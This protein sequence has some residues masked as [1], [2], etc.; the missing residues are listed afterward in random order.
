MGLGHWIQ[1]SLHKS[2]WRTYP[3]HSLTSGQTTGIEHSPTWTENWIKDLLS[4]A[5]SSERERLRFSTASP[6]HQE[7]STSL[8]P[9]SIR[10]QTESKPQLQETNQNR[11]YRKL[12][13][14]IIWITSL[15]DSMKLWAVPCRATQDGQVMVESSDKT[16]S[17]GGGNGKPLQYSC[18]ENPMN[19][20]KRQ[21]DRKDWFPLGWTGWISLQS[22]GLLRVFSNTTVQ[23]AALNMPANLG[24]SA[25]DTGLEKVHFHSSPKER[26]CQRMFKLL[27]NCTHLTC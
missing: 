14:L 15:S 21:R 6:S 4:L 7:V 3:Y 9:L 22:K 11:N 18:L 27:Q 23:N 1:Q 20:M 16:W 25:V 26:A 8:L 2:F 17:T 13:K 10:G 5:R 12:T 19:S 24:T